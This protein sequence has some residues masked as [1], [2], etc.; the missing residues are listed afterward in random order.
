MNYLLKL[1]IYTSEQMQLISD[2]AVSPTVGDRINRL[3]ENENLEDAP[4]AVLKHLGEFKDSVAKT[5]GVLL[6]VEII[7]NKPSH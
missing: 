2:G 7:L 5:G 1:D 4:S 3:R 6:R